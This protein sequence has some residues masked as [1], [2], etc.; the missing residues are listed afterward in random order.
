ML[1]FH[2]KSPQIIYATS[3]PHC[4]IYFKQYRGLG[5]QN[6]SNLLGFVPVQPV[7][8]DKFRIFDILTPS[9]T[10]VPQKNKGD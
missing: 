8:I 10:V 3:V 4:N 9:G 6:W 2:T 1:S 5:V 7:A